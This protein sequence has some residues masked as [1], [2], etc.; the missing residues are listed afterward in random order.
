MGK[1]AATDRPSLPMVSP[2]FTQDVICHCRSE[3]HAWRLR[4]SITDRLAEC[5]LELNETK[6]R[7]VYCKCSVLPGTYPNQSF[8]FL[9]YTFRPRL[10]R[11]AK[12]NFV[13]FIPG[14]SRTAVKEMQRQV[15][16]WRL[17]RWTHRTLAEV[18]QGINPIVRGWIQYYARYGRSA[19]YPFLDR[20]NQLLVRWAQHRYRRFER[21]K[22][23]AF[24]WLARAAR[25][26]PGLFAHW[27]LLPPTAR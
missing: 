3:A 24:R 23:K 19:L 26:H 2:S 8:D 14:V 11:A 12:G 4:R 16:R 7:I 15:R 6:T 20:L 27:P 22:R 9:G 21:R 10:A 5:R 25:Q 1:L 18:A 13:A 17:H